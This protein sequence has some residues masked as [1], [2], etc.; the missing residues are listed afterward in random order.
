MKAFER[1]ESQLS[2]WNITEGEKS[3]WIESEEYEGF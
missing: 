1:I 3:V 2:G